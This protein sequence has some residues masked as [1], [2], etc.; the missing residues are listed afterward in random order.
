MYK[1]VG[2]IMMRENLSRTA[3]LLIRKMK[4]MDYMC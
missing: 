3:L 4:V 1:I 2:H